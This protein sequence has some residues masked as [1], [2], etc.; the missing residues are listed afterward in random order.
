MTDEIKKLTRSRNDRMMAGVCS[1]LG[2]YLGI[3]PTVVRIVMVLAF[4][5]TFST[6]AF[7]YLALWLLV[8]E[9]SDAGNPPIN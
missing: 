6:A 5:L 2:K 3:D 7:V 4:F 8:P 9:E 1:G